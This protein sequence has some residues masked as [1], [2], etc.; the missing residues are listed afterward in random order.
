MSIAALH[1]LLRSAPAAAFALA[2][3]VVAGILLVARRRRSN[4]P[5]AVPGWPLIGNLLQL[6]EKKPH[7]TFAKWAAT[8]GPIYTIRTGTSTVVVLNSAELAKEAMVTKFSSIST[9]KLSKALMLLTSNKAMVAMSDYGDFHRMVKRY[10]LTSLLGANAQKHNRSYRDTMICNILN[11]LH[12]ELKSDPSRAIEFRTPFQA[13]IFR[14]S[15]KQALGQDVES[16][17]VEELGKEMT[18]KEI[19]NILVVDPMMG[20]IAVDWRDFFPYLS[21]IPNRSFETKIQGMVTRKMAVTRALIMEQKKR[22]ERGEE[23][24]CYLDF[25]LSEN[26]LTEEQLTTLVWEAIIEASDTTMVTTEWA[27][28]ELAKNPECQDR[29]YHE[30]LQVCG[31]EKVTEEHLPQMPY[32]NAVFHEALRRHSPVPIIPLRYAT[33]DTQLGGFNIQAGS[34]IAINLYACNMDKM[35]WE[36]PEEWKPE[37][38]LGDKFEQTDMHKTMAFGAGKRACAGTLQA[39]LISCV[40]IARFVQ[41][42]QWRLKE[43]E[44]AN[45]ATVQLTTHKLQPMQAHITPREADSARPQSS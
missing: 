39:M 24:N 8:Y 1:L 29:L 31:S 23:I 19:F 28:F 30:I 41:E 26:T 18:K 9:R 37:R 13:E 15:L 17:F 38:F 42:F 5:P 7:L 33:E 12:S 44:E 14:L 22:R 43:G 20:A 45:V 2:A 27:M 35:Q 4:S 11:I 34:E 3:A 40:A 36:E 16:I 6:K 25:L 10:V 32:L 21:W